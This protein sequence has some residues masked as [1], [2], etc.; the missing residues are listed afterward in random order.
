MLI[1]STAIAA[2]FLLGGCGGGSTATTA[3]PGESAA[4]KDNPT[5]VPLSK[6]NPTQVPM[7]AEKGSKGAGS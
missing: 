6:D 7:S 1:A 3:R 5:Q 4:Q 2:S